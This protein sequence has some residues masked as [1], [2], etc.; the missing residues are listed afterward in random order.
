[1]SLRRALWHLR[2]GG[3]AGLREHRRRRRA[4]RPTASHRR[5]RP[6]VAR[7]V[8][9]IPDWALPEAAAPR[10][11]VTAGVIADEFTS[12]ALRY[13]W[14]AVPLEPR[15]WREQLAESG[16]DLIFVESA[17]HGNDDAWIYQVL[18]DSAPSKGL[19][20]LI[21]AARAA[22]IPTV[23]WNKE[24]PAHYDDAIA[25]A[26]LFD[27]V[28]TTDSTLVPRYRAEL[29]HDRVGVLPFA[30][31]P[32]IHNPIRLTGPDG[33]PVER[34]GIAF[35]GMYFAHKYPERREQMDILLGAA[36]DAGRRTGHDLVIYS[37]YLGDDDRYQFP[38]PHDAAVR[39]SLDYVQML[40]AYR[41]HQV[42]LNVNSVVT[43]PSMMA[44]RIF[45]ITAC[46]TPVV[47]M[48]SPATGAF[49]PAGSLAI[50]RDRVGAEHAMRALC[51]NPELG[52]RMT[53]LAQRE[54][55]ARHTY[56]HR[57]DTVLADLGMP[58][59][60]R[61]TA[62]IAPLV[63][64]KRPHRL[65]AALESLAAQQGV[66]IRPVILTHGFEADDA[67]RACARELGLEATWMSA[68]AG[69]SLGANYAAMLQ[70]VEAD[71]IAK[72]DDDDLYGPHYLSEALAAIDYSG[73][74][75]VG[76]H[77]HYAHL[78]GS[79]LTVLRFPEWE[80]RYTSF[81][82]G[83]TIVARADLARAVGFPDASRGED[84][85]LL[86]GALDAGARV[87]STSRFGFVQRRGDAADHTWAIDDA[88]ILATSRISHWG[89]PGA[90][91]LP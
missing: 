67:A 63:A 8:A 21:A 45:E 84:T 74:G 50:A 51:A 54:I 11:E 49:L 83:P 2:H 16:L 46:G 76:K 43:S 82:S 85:A 53:H 15:R 75:I 7:G 35:A 70:R 65:V 12:L 62:S 87:Y 13:E 73:A 42:F 23:F 40:A 20:A 34:R 18:G 9:G 68:P 60:R 38:A 22:G 55:W 86:R 91:E 79:D 29:G 69:A 64:T 88:E 32:S 26:A 71:L 58:E 14:R 66:E 27:H 28:Y 57:V 17:W 78:A 39:G 77:A 59:R 6:A 36:A 33:R 90:T 37:R 89:A 19:R 47:T 4:A 41:A 31:Q 5:S 61:R 3:P 72:M 48:P 25:T 80:H 52:D 1:M 81:V 10:H 24:D 30:A 44:R 56:A